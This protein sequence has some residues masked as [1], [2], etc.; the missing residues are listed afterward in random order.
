MSALA[1]AAG[2]EPAGASRLEKRI[3]VAAGLGGG[4]SDAATA[5]RLANETLAEPSR[6]ERSARARGRARR[7]C[8]VLP[9]R[10]PQLGDGDGTSSRRSTFRRTTGSSSCLPRR[11]DKPSTAVVYERVRRARRRAGLR[12]SGARA[13]RRARRSPAT[14][15]P[16]AAAR[17]TTSRRRRW[18]REL[19]ELGAFRADVSGAGPAVYGLF[20]TA[21]RRAAS[22]RCGATGALGSHFRRGTVDRDDATRRWSTEH[23]RARHDELRPLAT[24]APDQGGARDR[25]RSR[26]SS[27]RS[28][29]DFSQVTVIA[30]ADSGGRSSTSSPG[31]TLAL[32]DT[33]RDLVDRSR[34]RRRSRS[35]LRSSPSRSSAGAVAARCSRASSASIALFLLSHDR[36]DG[37]SSAESW[38]AGRASTCDPPVG[39]SQVVRQRVLV[40]RSQ[41]RIL[42]PQPFSTVTDTAARS[43]V[44]AAGL[45]TRMRSATPKHLH[46]LLGRRLV[47]W[48]IEAVR[49]ARAEP[50]VVVTSPEPARPPSRA[51]T[52]AV[53]EQPRGTGD[54]VAAAR[55]RSGLRRATSS[56]SP[57]TRRCS[58]RELLSGSSR[59]TARAAP[60]STVLS[61]EPPDRGAYGRVVRDGDG[62]LA[63]IV[64]AQDATDERARDPRGELLDL[65]LR[66]GAL[67]PALER[68][69]PHNAQGELYL[70]D[71]RAPPRRRPA[72]ACA[73]HVRRRPGEAVGVNTR[74]ELAAA[75]AALRD[76]I[77]EA[78]MLAG[79]DDRR[80]GDDVDRP[81]R[82]ARARRDR[83]IPSRC[84]A[85]RHSRARRRGRPARRRG[86][87]RDRR[88]SA[89]SAP[90][91]TFA[92]ARCST[93][94]PRRA[95]SWR[96][97][98]RASGRGAKVPHLSYVGDADIGEDTNIGAGQHHRQLPPPA[99]RAKHRTTIGRNVRTGVDNA[100]VAPVDDRRRCV[101]RGRIGDHRGCPA[102][103]LAI[104]R[105][106]QENKE[107]YVRGKRDGLS[108][109]TLPGLETFEPVAARGGARALDRAR[110]AEA[111]DG[112]LGPVAS[113][114]SRERIAEQLGVELGEVELKTFANGETYCR[115]DESIRGADV[116]IVQSGCEPVNDT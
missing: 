110:A 6:A 104:A 37:D 103:A 28:S 14:H 47:D 102:G 22:A 80:P 84:C 11:R 57:A 67:W 63:A 1:E 10:R 62:S 54:A 79:V 74:A 83:S 44:M 9:R 41:V 50:L 108:S 4:S 86:R 45:G 46:P 116:F 112:L 61:F 21:T 53:Q 48:V 71:S 32:A 38:P 96:S 66:R 113:P 114:S 85:A 64:E 29:S 25:R 3:P 40:P 7:G 100:F 70:T 95:R 56:S 69:T 5:L 87:R 55:E 94:A 65:R 33:S 8:A 73:V 31:G 16:R 92:P 35:W 99:G 106:R 26:G 12:A 23:D 75:A 77:N 24:S 43:L 20:E 101:D 68:S 39:R 42:A 81:G 89:R 76:R 34:C 13:A 58:R 36:L 90:S 107:G 30:I 111:A 18:P 91:V 72:S 59:S 105:A 109:A 93:P 19:H 2:V 27:S 51:S 17:R 97:R 115:Y 98:T 60:R 82:R 49:A 52:V 78:H 88:R 15:R